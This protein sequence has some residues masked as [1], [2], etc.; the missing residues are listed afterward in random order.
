MDAAEL[1][2]N[3]SEADFQTMVLD[4]ARVHGWLVHHV[5]PGRTAG[6]GWVTAIQGDV[7]FP[8]LVLVH[9]TR[10]QVIFAELKTQKGKMTAGQRTWLDALEGVQAIPWVYVKVWRPADL[11]EI[12][13]LL[14]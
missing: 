9:K 5:R 7:G 8:D 11:P 2:L 4:L 12:R 3:M 14:R 13:E 10:E 6:G 1:A